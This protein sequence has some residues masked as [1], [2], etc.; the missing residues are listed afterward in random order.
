[1]YT[2]MWHQCLHRLRRTNHNNPQ[3]HNIRRPYMGNG[4][5]VHLELLRALH[6]HRLRLPANARSLLPPLVED[7]G[8][9][10]SSLVGAKVRQS[11]VEECIFGQQPYRSQHVQ[12]RRLSQQDQERMESPQF[13]YEITRRRRSRTH[14]QDHRAGKF[15]DKGQ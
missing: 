11:G 14:E 13:R 8:H 12:H 1:M 7:S 2:D 9:A 5:T 10:H 6:R 4:S 3:G 15:A